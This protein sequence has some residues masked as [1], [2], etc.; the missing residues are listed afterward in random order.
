MT[1]MSRRF[2]EPSIPDARRFV[3]FAD[4]PSTLIDHIKTPRLAPED[5][6]LVVSGLLQHR[7]FFPAQKQ[8]EIELA[9][10][11]SY[12]RGYY[13]PPFEFAGVHAGTPERE[14]PMA[15]REYRDQFSPQWME[16][17][18][19]EA[20]GG[21]SAAWIAQNTMTAPRGVSDQ[22]NLI[23]VRAYDAPILKKE[24]RLVLIW[25]TRVTTCALSRPLEEY[26]A[27]ML[28]SAANYFDSEQRSGVLLR[29]NARRGE[30][31]LGPLKSFGDPNLPVSSVELVLERSTP[32]NGNEVRTLH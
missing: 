27:A 15:L 19:P 17:E 10:V 25:E 29:A 5:L 23:T 31:K 28:A 32:L 9:I 22:V 6:R 26:A 20:Q 30:V 14:W 3:F 1:V 2:A 11:V 24:R 21:L 12:G 7:G 4:G 13:P 16:N 18:D 8:E